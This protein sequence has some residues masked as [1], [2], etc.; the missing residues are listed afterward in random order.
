MNG[1]VS[2]RACI[3]SLTPTLNHCHLPLL[4]P[5][6]GP[7]IQISNFQYF[8]IT[9]GPQLGYGIAV[10]KMFYHS[11]L[12]VNVNIE[13]NF[14]PADSIFF[15]RSIYSRNALLD[16][17]H[18]IPASNLVSMIDRMALLQSVGTDYSLLQSVG[19][20]Y[21]LLAH[22]DSSSSILVL[23]RPQEPASTSAVAGLLHYY[24]LTCG[25]DHKLLLTHPTSIHLSS[26]NKR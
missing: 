15:M 18:Q 25:S 19:T 5:A 10:R 20:D 4:G 6:P 24:T 7:G 22:T 21:S 1:S 3:K 12:Y 26:E 2:P 13:Q 23:S 14:C 9:L 8:S 17:E 11:Y 16:A